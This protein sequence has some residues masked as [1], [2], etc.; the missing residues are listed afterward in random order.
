VT[1][2]AHTN[3]SEDSPLHEPMDGEEASSAAWQGLA[4]DRDMEQREEPEDVI[5]RRAWIQE[6]LLVYLF[7]DGNVERWEDVALRAVAVMRRFTP[8][9]LPGRKFGELDGM[10]ERSGLQASFSMEKFDEL[11]A[12]EERGRLL[13]I[14]LG[15][16]FPPG[17]RWLKRGTRRVYLLARTFQPLLL[18]Q[19]GRELGYE[20]LEEIF[21]GRRLETEL[22]RDRARSRW[23][24]RAQKLIRK[25]VE[26]NGGRI[27]LQFGKSATARAKSAE[28]ARGNKN[29]QG[30]MKGGSAE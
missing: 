14:L 2:H 28:S 30:K 3:D 16:L 11:T 17:T 7:A 26:A 20:R 6:D 10:R 8:G 23:S 4:P 9:L 29:R 15:Y 27:A 24:A 25:P 1:L 13:E 19:H 18:R 21:E 5:Y 22:E 12:C